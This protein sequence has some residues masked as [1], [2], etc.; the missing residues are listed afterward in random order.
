[1]PAFNDDDDLHVKNFIVLMRV[2]LK[3]T[4]CFDGAV[5]YHQ[6]WVEHLKDSFVIK[7]LQILDR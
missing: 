5:Q 6:S 2:R 7:L 4:K 3:D 1:M